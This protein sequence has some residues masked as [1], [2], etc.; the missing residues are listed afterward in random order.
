MINLLIVEDNKKDLNLCINYLQHLNCGINIIATQTAE[1]ALEILSQRI[2]DGILIDIE[3]PGIDGLSLA[4]RIRKIEEYLFLPVL[5]VSGTD[6]D[7]PET[8]K[9]HQNY[10][11]IKKPFTKDVFINISKQFIE[12]IKKQQQTYLK[13]DDREYVFRHGENLI[14]IKFSDILYAS[15]I[16]RKIKLVTRHN[17]YL[18]SDISLKNLITEVNEEMFTLCSKSEA[19]NV[20]NIDRISPTDF[21]YKSRTIHFIDAPGITCQL[22]YKNKKKIENLLRKNSG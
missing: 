10:S 20:K 8:Y 18:R 4:K 22:S 5:F 1:D 3:L 15:T 13:N 12:H 19:V 14:V 6:N 7:Y 21:S 9:Q 17:E 11:F 2:I 16:E